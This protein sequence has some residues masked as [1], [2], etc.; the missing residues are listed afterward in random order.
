MS[1]AERN[2][3]EDRISRKPDAQAHEVFRVGKPLASLGPLFFWLIL[4]GVCRQATQEAGSWQR[5]EG[6]VEP[7]VVPS[8]AVTIPP[9]N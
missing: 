1:A 3:A 9:P 7:H 6:A 4:L 8:V 5:S 2:L